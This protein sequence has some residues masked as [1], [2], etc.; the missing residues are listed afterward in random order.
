MRR[1]KQ[2]RLMLQRNPLI[3]MVKQL[4]NHK[5]RLLVF[6]ATAHHLWPRS[7]GTSRPEFFVV[8]LFGFVDN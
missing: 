8:P 2:H 5:I 7:G 4:A 3:A 1:S 6:V